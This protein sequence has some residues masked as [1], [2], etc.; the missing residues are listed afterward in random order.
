MSDH[1]S[2]LPTSHA[3]DH[4]SHA[5]TTHDEHASSKTHTQSTKPQKIEIKPKLGGFFAAYVLFGLPQFVASL[6]WL[7]IA[8]LVMVS[9]LISFIGPSDPATMSL[10]YTTLR[11]NKSTADAILIYDLTGAISTG[12]AS[13]IDSDRATGIYTEL[14][15]RDFAKIK[16]DDTIKNVVFRVNT[17]GGSVFASKV[18]GDQ[19][20][21]LV[22]SKGQSEVV[23]Y[24]DQ[25]VASGGL[26]AAYKTNN[27]V[28]GSPYG[29][30]GSIGV[31]MSLPNYQGL[32]DKVGYSETI[33]KSGPSKDIGNPLRPLGEDERKFLQGQVDTVYKEF[34][35]V[36]AEGRELEQAKV[37][38]IANGY[39]YENSEALKYGLID[40]LGQIDTAINK[41]ASNVGISEY[42]VYE[43]KTDAGF[44]SLFANSW[45]PALKSIN[46]V[47][48]KIDSSSSLQ[49]GVVYAIDPLRI[50]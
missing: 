38:P 13:I 22:L 28:V 20:T 40:E 39:V 5:H 10:S 25:I 36:V 6:V 45:F 47:A 34:I 44:S 26:W 30:T 19:L 31:I 43:V 41:A 24:F 16:A 2:Q 23:F 14:V 42:N 33:I 17:P 46:K 49:S 3:L 18:L 32:A 4:R 7:L 35:D 37:E 15:K 21:D 12:D 27:Y 1:S 29:Q 8:F 50:N 9:V 48:D 11:N